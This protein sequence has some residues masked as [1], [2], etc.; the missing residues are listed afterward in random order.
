VGVADKQKAQF[1]ENP[2]R[3]MALSLTN[4]DAHRATTVDDDLGNES[5]RRAAAETLSAARIDSINTF[6]N[7]RAVAP[8][9]TYMEAKHGHLMVTIPPASVV[10]LT[11]Q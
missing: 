11:T 5:V 2:N 3:C 8:K 4:L 9:T 6:D 10:V 1:F 7:P